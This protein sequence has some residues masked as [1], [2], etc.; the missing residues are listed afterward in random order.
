MQ[1]MMAWYDL[2]HFC[3]IM[4]RK[5]VEASYS[6]HEKVIIIIEDTANHLNQSTN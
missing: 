1:S 2:D 6:L 5:L 3:P 4:C